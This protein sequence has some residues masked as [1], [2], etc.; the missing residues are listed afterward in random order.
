M[1]D[2]FE[3]ETCQFIG[4]N[5]HSKC[6][7]C[8]GM[9]GKSGAGIH[10]IRRDVGDDKCKVEYSTIQC[11]LRRHLKRCFHDLLPH[12]QCAS[13]TLGVYMY[14]AGLASNYIVSRNPDINVNVWKTFYDGVLSGLDGS[15]LNDIHKEISKFKDTFCVKLPPPV[16]FDMRQNESLEM[17]IAAKQH[18]KQF[19]TRLRSYLKH[20]VVDLQLQ[21]SNQVYMSE[22]RYCLATRTNDMRAKR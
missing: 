11:G 16:K 22:R 18:L 7:L 17:A 10:A 14:T 20:R 9:V 19:G 3:T 4:E 6:T 13:Q 21:Q 8:D 12:F 5:S 2:F 15:K 1:C